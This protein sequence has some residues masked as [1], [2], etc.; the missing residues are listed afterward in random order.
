MSSFDILGVSQKIQLC[1][2]PSTKSW[3]KQI[4]FNV[5]L[6][7][8]M[9]LHFKIKTKSLL[10]PSTSFYFFLPSSIFYLLLPPSTSSFLL[11]LCCVLQPYLTF[12][13]IRLLYPTSF[14][15]T[16]PP[17]TFLHLSYIIIPCRISLIFSYIPLYLP[18]YTGMV[19]Y[20]VVWFGTVWWGS[21]DQ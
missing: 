6:E 10:L 14:S 4:P 7:I 19:W 5:F 13:Q 8:L 11:L 9:T 15:L 12:Y 21:D 16:L 17:L 18:P 1:H 2:P 3:H 20:A